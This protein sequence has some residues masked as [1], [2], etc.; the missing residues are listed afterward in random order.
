MASVDHTVMVFKNGV[1]LKNQ[2]TYNEND[3][4]IEYCPFKYG[5]DGNIHTIGESYIWDDIT[6]YHG[7]HNAYYERAG[8]YGRGVGLMWRIKWLFHIKKF[9]FYEREIGEWKRGDER[10]YI[11]HDPSDQC[12]VS[13]YKDM[14]GD[15][16]IV[17]GGY[18]HHCNVYTHFMHRGYGAEFEEKMAYEAYEW[19]VDDVLEEMADYI[20]KG[21]WESEDGR[22][23]LQRVFGVGLKEDSWLRSMIDCE[24][25]NRESTDTGDE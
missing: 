20:F 21:F 22:V 25:R 2:H 16:Y 15:T 24:I 1:W 7:E 10:L 4:F 19:C 5:R 12:Y 18:G 9:S 6:W 8:G 14:S 17:L 3:E 11:Y 23:E 13:F